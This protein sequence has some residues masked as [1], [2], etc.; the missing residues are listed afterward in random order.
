MIKLDINMASTKGQGSL[1]QPVPDESVILFYTAIANNKVRQVHQMLEE[2]ARLVNYKNE[3]H[4]TALHIA[5]HRKTD[6]TICELLLDYGADVN[7]LNFWGQSIT[8]CSYT[9]ISC[10]YQG[11]PAPWGHNTENNR[12]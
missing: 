10:G 9:W 4:E 7:A 8:L 11:S 1:P 2:N 12:L 5:T 3:R 6:P